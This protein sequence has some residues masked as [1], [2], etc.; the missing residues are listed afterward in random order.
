MSETT[1]TWSVFERQIVYVRR[2]GDLDCRDRV[3]DFTY[4]FGPFFSKNIGIRPYYVVVRSVFFSPSFFYVHGAQYI[5]YIYVIV[6]PCTTEWTSLL[7]PQVISIFSRS[8]PAR[9]PIHRLLA[10]KQT[11]PDTSAVRD[12]SRLPG[13]VTAV[14]V[15]ITNARAL[16]LRLNR[17]IIFVY[18]SFSI[19]A[20]YFVLVLHAYRKM[21]DFFFRNTLRPVCVY[22]TDYIGKMY[23][24]FLGL[25]PLRVVRISMRFF[26]FF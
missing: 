11:K 14:S 16:S 13:W 25:K 15:S 1:F 12:P 18:R 7:Y 21:C 6:L 22:C 8:F 9:S 5:I 2:G 24:V 23:T 19:D 3:R 4:V 20:I 26:F 10:W 17:V